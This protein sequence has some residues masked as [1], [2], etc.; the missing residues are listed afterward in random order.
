MS[1]S[2]LPR[3]SLTGRDIRGGKIPT[4]PSQNKVLTLAGARPRVGFVRASVR[5]PYSSRSATTGSTRIARR[6]GTHAAARATLRSR[7][8]H[9]KNVIG[10][11]A[12]TP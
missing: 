3:T 1:L 5:D 10:S 8:A 7:M 4:P 11:C 6:A 9:P 12:L 2:L